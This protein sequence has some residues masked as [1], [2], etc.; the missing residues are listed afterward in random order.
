MK[1]VWFA[2]GNP[3]R[4]DD[5]VAHRVMQQLLPN[6]AWVSVQQLT[7]ELAAE[8]AGAGQA[9]FVDADIQAAEASLE[10]IEP[11][12][13]LGGWTHHCAPET[14]VT[15]A[16]AY[17]DFA[18]EAYLCRIPAYDFTPG[19]HLSEEAQHQAARA[20]ALLRPLAAG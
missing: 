6:V 14:I 15:L 9:V 5:G 17:F 18:G 3:W 2:I 16:R 19:D 4:G 12:A 20:I 13:P 10:R 11:S 7:P 1:Q 8:L